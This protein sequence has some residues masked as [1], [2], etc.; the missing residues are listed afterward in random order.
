VKELSKLQLGSV[1]CTSLV[2][3]ELDVI[4]GPSQ[5]LG[6]ERMLDA[7]VANRGSD[8]ALVV[9]QVRVIVIVGDVEALCECSFDILR[10]S[11]AQTNTTSLCG[12]I[13]LGYLNEKMGVIEVQNNTLGCLGSHALEVVEVWH[14]EARLVD[15]FILS[16]ALLCRTQEFSLPLILR[17]LFDRSWEE[18]RNINHVKVGTNDI[19]VKYALASH[20]VGDRRVIELIIT[21]LFVFRIFDY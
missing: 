11:L 3:V 12:T 9:L 8:L 4:I 2:V 20:F 17:L 15:E 13:N 16:L 21:I 10:R 18:C 1:I 14:G 7:D 5:L 19:E 6:G